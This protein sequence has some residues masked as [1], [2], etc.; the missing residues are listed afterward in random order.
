[1]ILN[2]KQWNRMHCNVRNCM[3]WHEMQSNETEFIAMFRNSVKLHGM[4]I[5]DME[6]TAMFRNSVEWQNPTQWNLIYC[7]VLKFCE[8]V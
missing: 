7:Y 1:M 8:I 6:C 2:A 5:Y 4:Q 3:E